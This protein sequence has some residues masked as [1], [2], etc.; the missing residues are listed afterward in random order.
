MSVSPSGLG[1]DLTLQA[2][3]EGSG[4]FTRDIR[5]G[6]ITIPAFAIF[7]KIISFG[8]KMIVSG[9]VALKDIEITDETV[10][11][12]TGVRAELPKDASTKIDFTGKTGSGGGKWEPTMTNKPITIEGGI[13]GSFQVFTKLALS[14]E[15]EFLGSAYG[16]D[17]GVNVPSIKLNATVE[18]G[19]GL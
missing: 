1:I 19:K 12:T 13:G 9:S 10:V 17:I 3:L 6:E 11:L 2:T 7:Q 4:E 8:P 18:E 14:V 15:A 16:M 5:F